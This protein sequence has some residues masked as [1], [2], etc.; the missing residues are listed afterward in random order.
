[1]LMNLKVQFTKTFEN[2]I[3]WYNTFWLTNYWLT[4]F[5]EYVYITKK[6]DCK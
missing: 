3:N 6:F 5:N 1:M 4:K 2:M